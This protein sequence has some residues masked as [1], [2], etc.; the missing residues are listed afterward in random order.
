MFSK[1]ILFIFS[2]QGLRRCRLDHPD[3]AV[4]FHVSLEASRDMFRHVSSAAS[5]GISLRHSLLCV[6]PHYGFLKKKKIGD[7]IDDVGE[8]R[9]VHGVGSNNWAQPK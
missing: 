7:S 4:V 2:L 8:S 3:R 9:F 6:C 1:N 5:G